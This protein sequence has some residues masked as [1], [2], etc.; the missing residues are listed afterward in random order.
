MY[1]VEIIIQ[2]Q[3]TINLIIEIIIK[4]INFYSFSKYNI[5][6]KYEI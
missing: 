2:K 5:L 3:E 1:I 4:R 6:I